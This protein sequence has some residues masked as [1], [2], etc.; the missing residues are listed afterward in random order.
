MTSTYRKST[1]WFSN[2]YPVVYVKW[3]VS[4]FVRNGKITAIMSETDSDRLFKWSLSYAFKLPYMQSSVFQQAVFHSVFILAFYNHC[5]PFYHIGG[6]W[7]L[8]MIRHSK[9]LDNQSNLLKS[10]FTIIGVCLCVCV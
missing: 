3:M 8:G 7:N 2:I 5:T 10:Y 6:T 1:N 4:G 9:K